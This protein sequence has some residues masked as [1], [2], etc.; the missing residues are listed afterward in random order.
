MDNVSTKVVFAHSSRK[1]GKRQSEKAENGEALVIWRDEKRITV[2][3]HTQATERD[4]AGR[5]ANQ[6]GLLNRTEKTMSPSWSLEST[7]LRTGLTQR[8]MKRVSSF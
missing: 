4:L 8:R 5:M 7:G 6:A 3:E 1:S 2:P